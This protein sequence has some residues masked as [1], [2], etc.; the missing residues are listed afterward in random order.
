MNLTFAD[1]VSLQMRSK[2]KVTQFVFSRWTSPKFRIYTTNCVNAK[3][4][5]KIGNC[6]LDDYDF[7]PNDIA[8][9]YNMVNYTNLSSKDDCSKMCNDLVN[10]TFF[11]WSDNGGKCQILNGLKDGQWE[12]DNTP[13]FCKKNGSIV[14]EKEVLCKPASQVIHESHGK[15]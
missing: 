9:S 2:D 6:S 13:Y 7:G 15:Y 8:K 3:E 4:S 12:R 14:T 11:S 10:C 5:D 1:F